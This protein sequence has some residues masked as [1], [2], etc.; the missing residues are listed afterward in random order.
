M[1][2]VG[3]LAERIALPRPIGPHERDRHRLVSVRIFEIGEQDV[4]VSVQ[5]VHTPR[6]KGAGEPPA[7]ALDGRPRRLPRGVAAAEV[8]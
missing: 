4:E 6:M 2:D 8:P 5:D 1:F 7:L 3:Q